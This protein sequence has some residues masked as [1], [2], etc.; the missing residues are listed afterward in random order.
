MHRYALALLIV[1]SPFSAFAGELPKEGSYE[2]TSCWSGVNNVI[3][4]SKIH[5]ASSFEMTGASRSNPPGGIFDKNTFRCV[6]MNA[7]FDGKVTVSTVCEATDV[8]GDKRLTT[9]S[10]SDGKV[11]RAFV[12]GTGKYEGMVMAGTVEPLGPFPVIKGGVMGCSIR[13]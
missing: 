6:G 1:A 11:T 3:T 5:T 4:F 12:A 10:T 2:Y 9:F 13:M 7:S 8:D